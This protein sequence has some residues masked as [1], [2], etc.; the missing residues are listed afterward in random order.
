MKIHTERCLAA[1][2]YSALTEVP[3]EFLA[4]CDKLET[5]KIST[6]D[7]LGVFRK[8]TGGKFSDAE[9]VNAWR[10]ILGDENPGIYDFLD[11][12]TKSGY[13]AIFFSDTSELHLDFVYRYLPSAVFVTG[14]IFSFNAGCKKP[15]DGMYELFEKTYGKPSFYADDKPENVE[16]GIRHGWNSHQFTSVEALR[17]AFF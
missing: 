17:K 4:A 10:V 14:G 5:G 9:L 12:I 8:V 7:W 6:E 1:L 11:E 13:R 2:G 3:L 16:G 15:G